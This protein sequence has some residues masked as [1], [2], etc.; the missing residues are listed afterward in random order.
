MNETKHIFLLAGYLSCYHYHHD[1]PTTKCCLVVETGYSFTHIVPYIL[2]KKF[3]PGIIRI[4]IGGKILTNH[5]KEVISYRQL[6]VMEETYVMN[7]CKEDLCFV[8]TDFDQ[9]LK[10]AKMKW[11]KNTIVRDYIL[12]D[13]TTVN[14]GLIKTLDETSVSKTIDK[15]QASKRAKLFFLYIFLQDKYNLTLSFIL[16]A[17][18]EDEQ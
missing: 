14:R 1:N 6:H 15:D 11:P 16:L 13:Y 17:N 8:S 2:Q 5:L 3:K 18:F 9:D 4:N 10:V 12:P 7:Q